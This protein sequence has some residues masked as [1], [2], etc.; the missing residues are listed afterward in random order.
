MKKA[1]LMS[2]LLGLSTSSRSMCV[3]NVAALQSVIN[4]PYVIYLWNC[5]FLLGL[6]KKNIQMRQWR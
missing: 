6:A 1:F 2:F 4:I 5:D 3:F